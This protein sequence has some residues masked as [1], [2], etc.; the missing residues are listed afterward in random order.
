MIMKGA[1][2]KILDDHAQ[3]RAKV[4][5][6]RPAGQSTV[7]E[8]LPKRTYQVPKRLENFEKA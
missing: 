2:P 3:N 6:L 4:G 7:R 1:P 5:D 8:I